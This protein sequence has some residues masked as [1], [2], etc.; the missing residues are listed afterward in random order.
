MER[1]KIM[2]WTLTWLNV[3]AAVLNA[4]SQFLVKIIFF[5]E[6]VIP[7]TQNILSNKQLLAKSKN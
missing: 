2:T 1:K 6:I 5:A 4:R 3:S 7:S